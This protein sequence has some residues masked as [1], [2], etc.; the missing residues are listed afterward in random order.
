MLIEVD[1]KIFGQYFYDDPHPFN[2]KAFVELNKAKAEKII[3]LVEDTEKPEIGLLA[4]IH[5]GK[6]LSPFS[7]PF[8]GFHF[9]KE[10]M[11]S[12][13]IDTFMLSFKEYLLSQNYKDCNLTLPPDIYHQTF[14]AK[15]VSALNRAGFISKTP[16]ITSWIDLQE[17]QD[18]YKQKNSREYYRQAQRNKLVFEQV[19]SQLDREEAYR[20][21]C[22]NRAK[23]NRPIYMSL[24]DLQQ[25]ENLWPVDFF[26]VSNPD[27]EMLASA[28]FYR[29]KH[30]VVYAVFWGDNEKGRPLRAMDFLLLNLWQFY[31]QH[32]YRYVDLGISTEDGIPNSGLL[33]FKETHEAVSSL[34]YRFA[35]INSL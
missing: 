26:K 21:I 10:N 33:R 13:K 6:L 18:K 12:H 35:L 28:I 15:C 22:Q 29:W 11:Y 25:I 9:K 20:L 23:F 3:R 32:N 5:K 30:Q 16:E 14:N 7:A 24:D 17:V 34:R 19:Q 2:T 27:G 8:G 4:G 31:K 1:E